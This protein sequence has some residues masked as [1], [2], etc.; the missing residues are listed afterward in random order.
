M[1][2]VVIGA[3]SKVKLKEDSLVCILDRV[4]MRRIVLRY[5]RLDQC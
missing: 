3:K 4:T 5:S 2:G 1:P